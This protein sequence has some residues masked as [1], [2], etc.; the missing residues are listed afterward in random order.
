LPKPHLSAAQA[1]RLRRLVEKR[2]RAF[3]E[4]AKED[5][6]PDAA[7]LERQSKALTALI[8]A[9]EAAAGLEAAAAPAR[10]RRPRHDDAIRRSLAQRLETLLAQTRPPRPVADADGG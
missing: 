2:L 4:L 10:R 7:A 1:R 9:L 3:E 8:R 6:T 5:G